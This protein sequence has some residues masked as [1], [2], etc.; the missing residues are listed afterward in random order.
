MSGDLICGC[1]Y[2]IWVGLHAIKY[3]NGREVAG[4]GAGYGWW[5]GPF[6]VL[7]L[8]VEGVE[9]ASWCWATAGVRQY[10]VRNIAVKVAG[11]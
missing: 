6:S 2:G 9:R 4:V 1:G 8:W 7:L 10:W 11:G 5:K 3:S